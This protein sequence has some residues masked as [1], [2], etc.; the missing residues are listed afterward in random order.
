LGPEQ[1]L[2]RTVAGRGYQFTGEIQPLS[3]A[4]GEAPD[5]TTVAAA[6]SIQPPTNLPEQVTELIGRE[7]ELADILALL[8]VCRLVNLTGPGGI[9]K[10][11]LALA[12]ARQLLPEFADGVWIAEFSAIAD[13]GLV[14]TTVAAAVGL[15]LGV[16]ESPQLVSQALAHRRLLL[17]LDTCEH[18]IDAA[19]AMAEALLQAGSEVCIIATSREPLRA[20]G[21]QIYQ[22]P[23]LALPVAE[24]EDPWRSGAMRLFVVRSGARGMHISEDQRVAAAIAG[25]CRQ[26]DGI[27]LAIEL[28]AARAA[29]LGIEVLGA[30]LDDR[31]GLLTGGRRTAL[32]RQQTLRATLDW[33]HDLLSEPERVILRRLAVF[34]GA[35]SMEAVS[36]VAA[37][38]ERAPSDVVDGLSNLAAK[39][40]AT[41]DVKGSVVRYRLLDTTRAYALEKLRDSGEHERL[42]RRHAEYYRDL[43]ERAEVEWEDRP[44]VEWLDDYVWCIDNL[45]AAL[46]WAFSPKGD[47]SIGVT[48]T[49]AAI[50]LWRHLSLMEECRNRVERALAA[51]AAGDARREMQ[52]YVALAQSLTFT[53]GAAITEVGAASAKA[54]EIAESLG[55]PDY[56][57]RA[58]RDLWVF[59]FNSGQHCLALTLAQKFYTLTATRLDPFERMIGERL[60]G[61]SQYYLGELPGARHLIERVLAHFAAPPQKSEIIRYERARVVSS[62][63]LARVLWLQGLPDQAMRTAESSVADARAINNAIALGQA[64]AVAA[65]P[66]A[67]WAGDLAAAEHYVEMLLDNST[68]HA[69]SRWHV[70]GRCYQG[71]LVIQRGDVATGLRL[72]R[73]AFDEPAAAGSAPRLLAFL[74]SAASGH[75]GQIADGLP[76]IEEAI[77]HS[78]NT[79]ERWLIAELLRVK[80]ELVVLRGKSGAAVTAEGHFRQALDLAHQQGALSWELRA[81]TSLARLLSDQGR[82]ADATAFLQPVYDRFTEGFATADL[83]SAKALLDNLS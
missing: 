36:A 26:L 50:P 41:V 24:A 17:I 40:L 70:Y 47:A 55:N 77:M 66:I 25:I 39:S 54:L 71:M 51:V 74:I 27:P 5:V 38:P 48:M 31:F 12:A 45:R 2:I 46:D 16:G 61:T 35:F 9:G 72:L 32:P 56:Q 29:T 69:L 1:G 67:L 33:S 62:A 49:A 43:F 6:E 73:A 52:L 80:G 76:A 82:S 19:A 14:S 81:A 58:L 53:R 68:R 8:A 75:A 44:I 34:A 3:A 4:T 28:A 42:L 60:I 13:P 10:T 20:E 37:D 11:R 63:V 78:E 59:R 64:L 21:E 15:Q 18:V 83:I 23:P 57:L 79:E 22:V 7:K 65:Y 30:H